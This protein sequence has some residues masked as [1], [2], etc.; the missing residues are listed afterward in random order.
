MNSQVSNMMSI[1][2]HVDKINEAKNKVQNGIFEMAE[3]ITEA[4]NQLD[5]RQAELSE[6][7]GMS[8]GTIS[9]W[10][11]I[12]SN[13]RLV[14]MKD[15]APLS[16]NSLYQLSSL[17]NQY[18]KIY[19]QKVAA[20]KFLELF[21][22]EKI[23]P[24][25]QRNDIDKIIRSQ[26][27]I[28]TNKTRDNKENIVTHPEGQEK[29]IVNSEMKLQV[30][31]KSNLFFNTII[32]V[33]SSNQ[34]EKWKYTRSD[35]NEDY[36]LRNLENPDKNILQQ[37]II[38]VKARDIDVAMSCLNNWGYNYSN[39]LIP[40]QKKNA[41]VS[42]HNEYVV[43]RGERGRPKEINSVIKSNNSVDLINYAENIGAEPFSFVGEI[44]K[45]KNWV[46]CVG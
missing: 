13:R 32:V 2:D 17:D 12:G 4:V 28:I 29:T 14:K 9:K 39:I 27:K 1:D 25:S 15:K 21:E 16:F 38:K 33:P 10:V 19:G 35:I 8:K 46:Y 41:L 44:V 3:A 23:T 34:L 37:C 26:K 43:I 30:L 42:I 7:L 6:K 22:N 20:K 45:V 36:P 40:N 18:N 31:I 24:L 5:G 11:S